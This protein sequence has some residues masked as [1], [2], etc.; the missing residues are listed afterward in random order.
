MHCAC[1]GKVLDLQFRKDGQ[2]DTNLKF[3][4]NLFC[5]SELYLVNS[6]SLG[7]TKVHWSNLTLLMTSLEHQ[8]IFLSLPNW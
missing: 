7:L 6:L 1:F 5:R 8:D 3:V 4:L 2:H